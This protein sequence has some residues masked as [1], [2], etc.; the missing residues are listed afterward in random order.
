[1]GIKL[2]GEVY[3][4]RDLYVSSNKEEMIDTYRV[5]NFIGFAKHVKEFLNNEK[6]KCVKDKGVKKDIANLNAEIAK[7]QRID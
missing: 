2:L 6:P 7:W 5:N 3:S 1:M 4:Q